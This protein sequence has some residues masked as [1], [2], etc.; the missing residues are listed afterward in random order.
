M[1]PV[2]VHRIWLVKNL[3]IIKKDSQ[4]LFTLTAKDDLITPVDYDAQV[5]TVVKPGKSN[6]F[7]NFFITTISTDDLITHYK[8]Q[9]TLGWEIFF[10]TQL[11]PAHLADLRTKTHKHKK[12]VSM[13]F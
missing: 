11:T 3:T 10:P 4:F 5:L 12:V 13:H 7:I 6:I 2:P 9:V 1:V 8:S